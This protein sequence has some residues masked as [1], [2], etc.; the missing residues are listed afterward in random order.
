MIMPKNLVFK[1]TKYSKN[2]KYYSNLIKFASY[3]DNYLD[4][5]V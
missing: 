3:Y 5:G 2:I 1:N 4:I